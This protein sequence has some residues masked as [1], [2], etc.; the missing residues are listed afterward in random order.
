M[1]SAGK[2]SKGVRLEGAERER[3][4]KNGTARGKGLL[5]R[6]E[7]RQEEGGGGKRGRK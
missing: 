5:V 3:A 7:E 6:S 2:R 4:K 1:V